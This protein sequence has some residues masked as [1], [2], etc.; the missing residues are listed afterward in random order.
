MYHPGGG[1]QAYKVGSGW[2]VVCCRCEDTTYATESGQVASYMRYE[3]IHSAVT[4]LA[5]RL[6][7]VAYQQWFGCGPSSVAA[8]LQQQTWDTRGAILKVN[9]RSERVTAYESCQAC[10]AW[11]NLTHVETVDKQTA[12]VLQPFSGLLPFKANSFSAEWRYRFRGT[13]TPP[14]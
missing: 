14:S 7:V 11:Q 5:T 10:A 12:F 13:Q 1:L 8:P 2:P 3:S 4:Y 6:G 9:Y